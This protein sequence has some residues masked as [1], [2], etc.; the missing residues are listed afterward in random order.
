[1]KSK[2]MA[3]AA[4]LCLLCCST[5]TAQWPLQTYGVQSEWEVEVGARILDRPSNDDTAD[6]A[7]VT[8]DPTNVTVFTGADAVDL[9]ASIGAD[10]RFMRKTNYD[11]SWE[12]RGFFNGWDNFESR[13]GNLRSEAFTPEFLPEF[14]NPEQ[15]D[16]GYDSQLF[17]IELTC[18]KAIRPGCNF[19]IGPRFVDFD[20]TVSVD[21]TFVNPFIPNFAFQLDTA[22]RTRNAMAGILLGLEIRRPLTRDIFFSGG[23][24]GSLLSN[25]SSTETT[26]TGTVVG[27][28]PIQSTIF[29][30]SKNA[31]A[32]IYEITA[33]LHYD[34]SPG[35]VSCYAGYEAFWMDAVAIAPT[36]L[37]EAFDPPSQLNTSNTTFVHGISFGLMVRA[38]GAGSRR[39]Y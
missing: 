6:L 31:A 21:S 10:F 35:N 37:F 7:L 4:F 33:R 13:S 9:N 22:N 2:L 5:A 32:G 19:L 12:V 36:Q 11:F 39:A 28:I 25:F 1:M 30:D 24:K 8:V 38:G 20:E 29:E 3:T 27:G 18:K 16:Y 23:V 14:S 34:I 17:S 26:S 15:F